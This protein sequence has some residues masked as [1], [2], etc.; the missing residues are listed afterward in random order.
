MTQPQEQRFACDAMCGG[1]ARWLRALGHDTYY[2]AAIEDGDLVR[3]AESEHRILITSDG[4]LLERKLIT[5]GQVAAL[6]L[7]HGL[8]L[9]DQLRFVTNALKLPVLDEPRCMTCNGRLITVARD[10]V[11][12]AV[13]ARSLIWATR[14]Y[15][16]TSC[17]R[18]FWNG[19]HWRRIERVRDEVRKSTP[20]HPSG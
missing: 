19:S 4:K 11:G 6:R 17:G 1:L 13:P 9:L 18:V 10:E 2:T 14:F 5:S 3:I 7:P 12:D 8:K 15:R 20:G 16:C